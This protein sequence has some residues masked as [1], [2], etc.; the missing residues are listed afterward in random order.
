MYPCEALVSNSYSKYSL[1]TV[2]RRSPLHGVIAWSTPISN[3]SD[4]DCSSDGFPQYP[5]KAGRRDRSRGP[6]FN[7]ALFLKPVRYVGQRDAIA[8][9]ETAVSSAIAQERFFVF[10]RDLIDRNVLAA[11]PTTELVD[12]ERLLPIR[13][14]RIST[15]G[16][17]FGIGLHITSQRTLDQKPRAPLST[18]SVHRKHNVGWFCAIQLCRLI[19][20]RISRK[21]CNMQ[22]Q[23]GIVHNAAY[24]LVLEPYRG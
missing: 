3:L 13:N 15:M 22:T 24:D 19:L 6:A 8:T 7:D 11:Q 4:S 20:L 2:E 23:L 5:V 16:E 10:A 17:I 12:E 21:G 1:T 14:L 9:L 18:C